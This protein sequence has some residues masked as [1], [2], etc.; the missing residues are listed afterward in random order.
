[1]SDLSVDASN[2]AQS[3]VTWRV[4]SDTLPTTITVF[5]NNGP[6]TKSLAYT[7]A[8][9]NRATA[10]VP[11]FQGQAMYTDVLDS[12]AEVNGQLVTKTIDLSRLESG[13]YNIWLRLENP[14]NPP[15]E[16]YATAPLSLGP[17]MQGG[18]Q[19]YS[20]E[21]RVAADGY[22]ALAQLAD[23]APIGIDNSAT[24]TASWST[25]ITVTQEGD[26]LRVIWKPHPSPDVD[27]YVLYVG[28]NP[29]TPTQV[30]DLDDV[31]YQAYDA[32]GDLIGEPVGN[33]T[34]DT[35]EPGQPYYI[36]IGAQDDQGG[37][38]SRSNTVVA[39]VPTGDFTVNANASQY[40]VDVIDENGDPITATV[41]ATL[42]INASADLFYPV[43]V[44]ANMKQAPAGIDAD[45]NDDDPT[46]AM[47][48]PSANRTV[49]VVFRIEP[50]VADGVYII[51]VVAY[52]GVVAKTKSIKIIVGEPDYYVF[53][54]LVRR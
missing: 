5:A 46:L 28:N 40:V 3:K 31:I 7:D 44:Y 21:I 37:R 4:R 36:W 50:S 12:L 53:L 9:G 14:R 2:K 38:I 15:V 45:V 34:L 16:G 47:L 29:T 54:P 48:A 52:S 22:D 27:A 13:A 42:Q 39:S 23:A 8:T 32:D 6:I 11:L 25:P 20:R 10:V 35:V 17:Q 33:A 24:L 49:Q 41:T 26:A 51:P 43:D 18:K 30:L 19:R 1:M